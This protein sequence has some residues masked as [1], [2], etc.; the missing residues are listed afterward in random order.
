[1]IEM[2][3]S[4]SHFSRSQKATLMDIRNRFSALTGFARDSK[5]TTLIVPTKSG[6]SRPEKTNQSRIIPLSHFR[7]TEALASP[8]L[9][10]EDADYDA[11]LIMLASESVLKDFGYDSLPSIRLLHGGGTGTGRRYRAAVSQGAPTICILDSDK[12]FPGDG[13]GDTAKQF[14]EEA[15]AIG[16]HQQFST[17]RVAEWRILDVHEMENLV[18]SSIIQEACA[19]YV[20]PVQH[21]HAMGYLEGVQIEM[22]GYG[23]IDPCRYIDRKNGIRK[24]V[25]SSDNREKAEFVKRVWLVLEPQA[26]IDKGKFDGQEFV[27]PSGG[28]SIIQNVVNWCDRRSR[29][30]MFRREL[31]KFHLGRELLEIGVDVLTFAAADIRAYDRIAVL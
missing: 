30:R 16:H 15:G 31:E 8:N 23:R 10:C 26:E 13:F 21:A 17:D 3:A 28:K 24:D 9:V 7:S 12:R 20:E 6:R 4:F 18:P 22:P 27:I 2:L 11:G 25:V 19:S 5:F 14:L 29:I 1:M